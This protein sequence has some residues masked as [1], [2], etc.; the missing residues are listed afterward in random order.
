MDPDKKAKELGARVS[1]GINWTWARGFCL[2][3]AQEFKDW[4]D[5]N[6]Y[7]NR[8]IYSNTSLNGT[9]DVRYR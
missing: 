7:E 1:P 2:S 3:K 6:N 4:L 5:A 8:G 9:Y